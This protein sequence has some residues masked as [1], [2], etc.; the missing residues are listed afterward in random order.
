MNNTHIFIHTPYVTLN[1]YTQ[2]AYHL[3]FDLMSIVNQI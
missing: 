2:S 1:S 3:T